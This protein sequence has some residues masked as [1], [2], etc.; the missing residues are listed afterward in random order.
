LQLSQDEEHRYPKGAA[1]IRLNTYVNDILAGAGTL[2]EALEV[3]DQIVSLLRA[4]GFQ[5]SKWAGTHPALCPDSNQAE[6]LISDADCVGAL[7]V[8][9]TST[10]DT[11]SLRAVPSLSPLSDLYPTKNVP[12]FPW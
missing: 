4:G 10:A 11:L 8:L 5:L 9:W 1:A 7:G 12:F 6:R 2:E 3:K